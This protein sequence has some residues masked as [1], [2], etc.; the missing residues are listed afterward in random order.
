MGIFLQ[1]SIYLHF[2]FLSYNSCGDVNSSTRIDTLII[3]AIYFASA[4][5]FFQQLGLLN[6]KPAD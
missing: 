4:K 2:T 6:Y 3:I 1:V 5:T